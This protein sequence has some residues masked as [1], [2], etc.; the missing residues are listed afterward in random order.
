MKSSEQM[1][2][3]LKTL[4]ASMLH[5]IQEANNNLTKQ[6]VDIQEEIRQKEKGLNETIQANIESIA[7]FV[8]QATQE[9]HQKRIEVNSKYA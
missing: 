4:E 8:Q 3:Q 9:L 7:G 2:A 6:G 1:T 5:Q